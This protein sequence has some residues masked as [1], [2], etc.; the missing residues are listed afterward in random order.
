MHVAE[1]VRV[2]VCRTK[3]VRLF[4]ITVVLLELPAVEAQRAVILH[5]RIRRGLRRGRSA[6]GDLV[7]HVGRA[8]RAPGAILEIDVPQRPAGRALD[9]F[10]S[11]RVGCDQHIVFGA[12][13]VRRVIG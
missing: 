1:S 11:D 13:C 2:D 8:H 4:K 5:G 9:V 7:D 6:P 12:R 3:A 10:L